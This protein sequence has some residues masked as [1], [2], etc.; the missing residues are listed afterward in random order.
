MRSELLSPGVEK[1]ELQLRCAIGQE[2]CSFYACIKAW[3]YLEFDGGYEMDAVWYLTGLCGYFLE[4][5]QK[6]LKEC[7]IFASHDTQISISTPK[8]PNI[9][10]KSPAIVKSEK[11]ED[12][13]FSILSK[14]CSPRDS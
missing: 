14:S 6:L 8:L 12:D 5:L 10:P 7:V 4:V 13:L 2:L 11:C 3:E 9:T 1:E